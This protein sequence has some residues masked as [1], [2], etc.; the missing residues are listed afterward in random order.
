MVET[1]FLYIIQSD[2]KGG[3]HLSWTIV[4]ENDSQT[5]ISR[6]QKP[7][8][9]ELEEKRQLAAQVL[10]NRNYEV[11]SAVRCISKGM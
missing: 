6:S 7:F 2:P 5:V 8:I 1:G 11:S 4:I 9:V 3:T 10:A